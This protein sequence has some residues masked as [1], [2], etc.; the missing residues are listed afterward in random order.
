MK[1]TYFNLINNLK[2]TLTL[3]VEENTVDVTSYNNIVYNLTW[4]SLPQDIKKLINLI[5]HSSTILNNNVNW[6]NI[7]EKAEE[8]YNNFN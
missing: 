6:F 8:I 3:P 1:Y 2:N 7:R 5:N 4:F